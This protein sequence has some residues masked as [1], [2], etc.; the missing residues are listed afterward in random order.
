M[1]HHRTPP[2]PA[3]APAKRDGSENGPG[4]RFPG[5]RHGRAVRRPDRGR[6]AVT[7]FPFRRGSGNHA[8]P[9]CGSVKPAA[10]PVS[11][12]HSAALQEDRS[13]HD[14]RRRCRDPAVAERE[15]LHHCE[16]EEKSAACVC[17]SAQPLLSDRGGVTAPPRSSTTGKARHAKEGRHGRAFET[18]QPRACKASARGFIVTETAAELLRSLGAVYQN[19]GEHVGLICGA[20]GVGKSKAIWYFKHTQPAV[21]YQRPQ[22]L[23]VLAYSREAIEQ[24]ALGSFAK[25]F[26]A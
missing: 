14:S 6:A 9:L 21:L 19:P 25:K 20:P 1:A 13:A 11:L 5:E 3:T 7:P 18:Y 23:T 26:Q 17:Q 2:C 10:S 22:G 12:G 4:E 15:I 8:A 24:I 16:N